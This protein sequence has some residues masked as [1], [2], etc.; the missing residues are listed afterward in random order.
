MSP[1]F[2]QSLFI[3]K[4]KK[5]VSD[6]L[7]SPDHIVVQVVNSIDDLNK[8]SNLAYERLT[9]WYGV[10]FPEFKHKDPET[11]VR[12][13]AF[14]DRTRPDKERLTQM[15]PDAAPAIIQKSNTSV[16]VAFDEEDIRVLQEHAKLILTMFEHKRNQEKYLDALARKIAPNV[17][18]LAGEQLAAKLVAH[19]GGIKKLAAMPASTIQVIGAEKALFKHLKTGSPPPKHGLI[20]QHPLIA[21]APKHARGKIARAL[22]AKIAIAAKADAYTHHSISGPLKEKFEARARDVMSKPAAP[23]KLRPSAPFKPHPRHAAKN[24]HNAQN[25]ELDVDDHLEAKK[26]FTP[27]NDS[28]DERPPR[29]DFASRAPRPRDGDS[30][31]GERRSRDDR[32]RSYAPRREGSYG[33]RPSRGYD[34]E[35]GRRYNDRPRSG[36]YGDRPSYGSKPRYNREGSYGDRPSRGYDREGGERGYGRDSYGGRPR[37]G[38]FKRDAPRGGSPRDFGAKRYKKGKR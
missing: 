21:S 14:F 33:D 31:G 27:R 36:G 16:G 38:G 29:R 7:A 25:P 9:E 17:S 34:R 6:E 18:D 12:V 3:K 15:L 37:S 8:I 23:K 30:Y 20:F 24:W 32:P 1:R 10:H 26:K 22:A 13:A 35:G 11:Y 28:S 4:A 5:G 19:A 2:D